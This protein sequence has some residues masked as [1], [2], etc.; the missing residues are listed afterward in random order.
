MK[1]TMLSELTDSTYEVD[2]FSTV[3]N[4]SINH[5]PSGITTYNFLQPF[6]WNGTSN[7]VVDF[8][9]SSN[10]TNTNY[11]TA[12]DSIGTNIGIVQGHNGHLDFKDDDIVDIPSSVFA[13]V[14]SAVTISFG[15][16]EMKI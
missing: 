3:Y 9:F 12:S 1:Q 2:N 4:N 13:N 16:M 8:V 10:S 6:A 14:D 5:H 15:V 11:T 7:I